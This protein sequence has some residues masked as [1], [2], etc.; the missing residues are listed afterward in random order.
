MGNGRSYTHIQTTFISLIYHQQPAAVDIIFM[1]QGEP[2]VANQAK[3]LVYPIT[4]A[5]KM[6]T[7]NCQILAYYPLVEKM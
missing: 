4:I 1:L 6:V 7:S 3:S 5:V 2:R